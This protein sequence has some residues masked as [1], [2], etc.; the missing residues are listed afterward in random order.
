MSAI[1]KFRTNINCSGCVERVTPA[2]NAA[3]FIHS[4]TVN[5]DI[6]D[7]VLTVRTENNRSEHVTSGDVISLVEDVGFSVSAL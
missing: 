7:K 6:P 4:W 3:E 5:T 1:F 2:L